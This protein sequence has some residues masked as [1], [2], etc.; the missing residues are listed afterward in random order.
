MKNKRININFLKK[1]Y[2]LFGLGKTGKIIL[3]ELLNKKIK[4]NVL[5]NFTKIKRYKN[6]QIIKEKDL[7]F[8]KKAV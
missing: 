8:E 6:I 7:L 5:N 4:S 1:K 2:Y 3:K